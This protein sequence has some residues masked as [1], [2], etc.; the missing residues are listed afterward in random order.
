[1][2]SLFIHTMEIMKALQHYSLHID[3]NVIFSIIIYDLLLLLIQ[4][5]SHCLI[6]P[7]ILTAKWP[8]P[9]V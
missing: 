7:E 2:Q 4:L 6:V 1:M 9:K 8:E 5:A 3:L